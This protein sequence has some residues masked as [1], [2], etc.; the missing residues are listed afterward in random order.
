[1]T[2]LLIKNLKTSTQI[3]DEVISQCIVK[4]YLCNL[5]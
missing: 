3:K 1:L 4:E 2:A 5:A